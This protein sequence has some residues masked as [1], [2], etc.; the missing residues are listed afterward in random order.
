MYHQDL[1]TRFLIK[2]TLLEIRVLQ[3]FFT[4]TYNKPYT[5]GFTACKTP[6]V[7]LKSVKNPKGRDLLCVGEKPLKNPY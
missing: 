5:K 1:K 3:G 2:H 6:K 7:F 4:N